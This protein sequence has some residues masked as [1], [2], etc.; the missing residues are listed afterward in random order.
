MAIKRNYL[1]KG[2]KNPKNA[3]Y[4]VSQNVNNIASRAFFK[5]TAGFKNNLEGR[6]TEKKL[7]K[8]GY[9]KSSGKHEI[10]CNQLT[11]EGFV[12]LG[13]PFDTNI[14]KKITERYNKM[15]DDDKY[16]LIRSEGTDGKV[17]CRM[18][19]RA[20]NLFPEVASLIT[21]DFVQ[22]ITD[23]YQ[24]NFQIL[25]VELWRTYHVPSEINAQKEMY[26][27]YWHCDGANTSILT[28]FTNLSDVSEENGPLHFQSK[29]RTKELIKNGYK[30]R[31][32]YN[33]PLKI[34]NDSDH[35]LK[36]TGPLGSTTIMNTQHCI[37]RAGI[38]EIGKQRDMMQLR[39]IP[40]EKPLHENWLEN[41][42][43][44]NLEIT[45]NKSR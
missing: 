41:C 20:H 2:I 8:T 37:H 16:S 22:K 40:S 9:F 38:P 1:I 36:A 10:F 11:Q 29:R 6:K 4:V 32:N 25:H 45:Y 42:E 17:Y 5:N 19:N 12:N 26:G 13:M 43:D 30:S 34:L 21:D 31:H 33:L 39:F 14:L 18:I 3:W 24:S 44:S 7:K 23:Y 35:I 15:I 28:S 27:S